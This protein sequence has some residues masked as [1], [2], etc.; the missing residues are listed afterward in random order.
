[1][2]RTKTRRIP[3]IDN[4][5]FETASNLKATNLIMKLNYSINALHQHNDFFKKISS[6]TTNVL[7]R[8]RELDD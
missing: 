6:F 1:M 3:R 4:D 8:L 5:C 2:H 7:A